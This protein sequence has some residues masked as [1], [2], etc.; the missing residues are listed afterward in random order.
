DGWTH[1]DYSELPLKRRRQ[2]VDLQLD[3]V[4]ASVHG[5]VQRLA[6]VADAERDV[7]RYAHRL[8][9]GLVLRP[10][11][12]EGDFLAFRVDHQH[13]GPLEAAAG[14]VDGPLAVDRH[15][16]AAG[17]FAKVVDRL[18][19]PVHQ[20]V[21]TQREGIDLHRTRF[22]CRLGRIDLVGAIVVVGQVEGA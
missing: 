15:A 5:H 3:P 18:A 7:G 6:L 11:G 16:I 9:P 17:F 10:G 22:W 12:N 1:V 13:G 2:A 8:F 4:Q 20:A 19:R 21:L 14:D